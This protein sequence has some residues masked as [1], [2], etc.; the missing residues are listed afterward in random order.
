MKSINASKTSCNIT[1][2]FRN[3]F[4][5]SIVELLVSVVV[6]G[7]AL[8]GITELLWMN[9]SWTR[10]F[11]NKTSASYSANV[12][13]TRL[14]DDMNNAYSVSSDS[15]SQQLKL[16]LPTSQDKTSTSPF[17]PAISSTADLVVYKLE[18]NQ[19]TRTA[20]GKS[21]TLMKGVV[22]PKKIG[23]SDITLFQYV[24][25]N[26]D[27]ADPNFGVR[28]NAIEGVRSVIVDLEVLNRDYGKSKPSETDNPSTSD[29][30]LR[31]EF[32]ARNALTMEP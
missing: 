3:S 17:P 4:G 13:L 30:A 21:W 15:T 25:L 6:M 7:V 10:N 2:R 14:R 5:Q 24:P 29:L 19:V 22:G 32:L 23:S 9:T 20:G 26:I 27:V 28:E 31:A 11:L 18:G 12:F 1:R 8:A 16:F